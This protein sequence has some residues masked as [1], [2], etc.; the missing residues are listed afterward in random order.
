MNLSAELRQLLKVY[1]GCRVTEACNRCGRLLGPVRF[2]RAGD[3]GAWCSR[4][5]RDGVE[6]QVGRCHGCRVS[7]AGQRKGTLFC[8][9][10]CR[11]RNQVRD[12][13]NIPETHIQNAGLTDAKIGSGYIPTR[14]PEIDANVGGMENQ[15]A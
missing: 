3:S 14:K 5:C 12:K 13:A 7:L 10:T 2:T 6:H 1:T 4:I 8:S 9:D 15:S 11:K